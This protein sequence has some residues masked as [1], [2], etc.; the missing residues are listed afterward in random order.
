MSKYYVDKFLYTVDRDP[1]WVRLY[2]EDPEGCVERWEKEIGPWI[3]DVEPSSVHS[4]TAEE[5]RALVERDYVALFEMGAHFFL[6]LTLMIAVFDEE[7]AQKH[8]PL[9]FQRQMAKD[10]QHW[11]GKEYPSVAL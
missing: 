7:W 1:V 6:N 2:Q 4:F 3:S 5:R 11:L 10:L 9:S 8:G